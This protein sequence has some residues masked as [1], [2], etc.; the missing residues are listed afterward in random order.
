MGWK[1]YYPNL[2]YM[3]KEDDMMTHSVRSTTALNKIEMNSIYT[4]GRAVITSH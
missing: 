1:F 2:F 3:Y 4:V